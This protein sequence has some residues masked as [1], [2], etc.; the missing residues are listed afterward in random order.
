MSLLKTNT[1]AGPKQDLWQQHLLDMLE[2]SAS[3]LVVL[4]TVRIRFR[5]HMLLDQG[6]GGR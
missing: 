3:N 5:I 4:P 6:P 2:G 1:E